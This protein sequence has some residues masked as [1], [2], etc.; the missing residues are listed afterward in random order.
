MEIEIKATFD[1]KKDLIKSLKSIG[2]KQ[3][4]QSTRLMNI[5][6]IQVEIQGRQKNIFV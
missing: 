4:K 1:N 2:A 5:I 3:E 6:I